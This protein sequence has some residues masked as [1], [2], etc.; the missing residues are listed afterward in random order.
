MTTK[1]HI[2]SDG[3]PGKCS[4]QSTESCPKTQAGDS[5]HGNLQEANAESAK[6]FENNYGAFNTARRA[7]E[8]SK[9]D[10]V[11]AIMSR[12]DKLV[13][14]Y[15]A[16]EDRLRTAVNKTR[17]QN[18]YN[19]AKKNYDKFTEESGWS[20]TIDQIR[21]DGKALG[22]N[23]PAEMRASRVYQ[24]RTIGNDGM[25]L[26]P[27]VGNKEAL[28]YTIGDT[29]GWLVAADAESKNE[30]QYFL[31]KDNSSQWVSAR[32]D[33]STDPL[34]LNARKEIRPDNLSTFK[35]EVGSLKKPTGLLAGKY[36]LNGE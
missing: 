25:E 35:K 12:Y 14:E 7:E 6:R 32:V 2:K 17:S 22:Y 18:A 16:E 20:E 13:K 29:K 28:P 19:K 26:P 10:K 11:E 9:K 21:E 4:A 8:L 31:Y 24:N 33:S 1:Y 30:V 5:F 34:S 23:S 3:T 36:S 15:G 27:K